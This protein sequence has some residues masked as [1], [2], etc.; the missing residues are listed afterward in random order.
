MDV[1]QDLLAYA[2]SED[3]A[4]AVEAERRRLVELLQSSVIE[5]LN[6]LLS[7]A[8]AY[9]QTLSANPQARMAV[10]VL[11]SLARQ[12]L[13][14][15]RDLEAS[16]S[17]TV[18]E[19]LGLEPALEVLAGQVMRVH[20]LQ[21]VLALERL[22]QRLPP[23]VEL[24]LFRLTQDALGRAVRHARASRVA[25]RLG[26]Q[27]ERVVLTLSDDGTAPLE[28]KVLPAACSQVGRLGGVIETGVGPH[29]G[30]ELVVRFVIEPPVQL[31][32]REMDVLQ[33]LAEGLSNKE[34]AQ[35]LAISPRT[36]NFHLDNVYSKLH[37]TSRT[38]AA[39]YAL[40]HGWDHQAT[41]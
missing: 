36:V 27:G 38:E 9:E 32:P 26:Q 5:P 39:V 16:L 35:R 8:N 1:T 25:I 19:A 15:A 30:L 17:P 10:S 33:L 31:T 6:L 14:Q 37:V 40:R 2:A 22:S 20:G 11:A 4:A 28:E 7:Q 3:A 29:G 24:A 21:V 12:V 23:R 18:L 41:C 13:Q 34:I